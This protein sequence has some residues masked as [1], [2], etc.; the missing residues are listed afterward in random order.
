MVPSRDSPHQPHFHECLKWIMEN[1]Q[2]DGSW[3]LQPTHP[4]LVKD[5]L[6]STLASVL[7]LQ[8]WQV[9]ESSLIKKGLDFIASN[10]CAAADKNQFSPIGFDI[11]FPGMTEY[12]KDMGL[13][14]P[15]KPPFLGAMLSKRDL[16][17]ERGFSR[18]KGSSLAYVAEGWSKLY[19]WKDLMKHQ[20][21]NGSLFNSP[22]TT[23]AALIHLHDDKCFEYLQSLLKR[24][25]NAV[26]TVYPLDIYTHHSMVD[27]LQRLGIDCHFRNEIKS[28]LDDT[29]LLSKKRCWLQGDEEIFLDTAC[30]AMGF[31]IL[32]ITG[33]EVSSDALSNFDEQEHFF[34]SESAQ[35]KDTETILELYKASL[36]ITFQK[37]PVLDKIYIWTSSFL[38]QE[39]LMGQFM[40]KDYIKSQLP[41][42]FWTFQ[43]DYA[44]KYP[45]ASLDRLES[46]KSIKHYIVNNIRL[47]KTS[48]RCSNIDNND[49]LAYS[50]QDFD[51][52]Q[53]M[54]RKELEHNGLDH[55][56]FARQKMT[57]AYF[58]IASVL[59]SPEFSDARI[60]W[61]KNSVLV[62]LVDDLF[63]V[64]GSREELLNIMELVEKWDE[65]SAIGFHS[66]QVEIIFSTLFYTTNELAAKA[67]IQQGRSVK[68]HL[69]EIHISSCACSGLDCLNVYIMREAEWVRDESIPRMDEY[70]SNRYVTIALGPIVLVVIYFLG[71]NLSEE[72]VASAEYESLYKHMSITGRLLNDLQT[73]NHAAISKE[74]A[75]REMR[76]SIESNRKEL[77]RMV[78]LTKGS[79]VPKAC[80]DLF[81]KS[82]KILHLFYMSKDGFTCQNEMVGAVSAVIDDPIIIPP[83][84]SCSIEF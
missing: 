39:L 81:W 51:T 68:N 70:M 54:H 44:L 64:G 46:R 41:F 23:A 20:R 53:A 84:S 38:K 4:L 75:K 47:L 57:Y 45:H 2:P 58:S 11:I 36:I 7:A 31:R 72:V 63:D 10:C 62:T 80:R 5:S 78:L 1:Q 14:L 19:D 48:Y 76:A 61:A 79:V 32:R 67:A 15:L 66:E 24:Y 27:N 52:C 56:K 12:A 22:S 60:S 28:I 33:Y 6:S 25:K 59:F 82:S 50:V 69:T 26:P 73:F 34:N 16:E 37:E 18:N 83:Y 77:L 30:C 3:G 17:V 8:K 29:R 9:G 49:F 40:R 71:R 35:F 43:V 21:S 65:H 55:L 42:S 13:N 74:E